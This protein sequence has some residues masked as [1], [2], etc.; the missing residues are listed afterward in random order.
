VI[1]PPTGQN[2][3]ANSRFLG[4]GVAIYSSGNSNLELEVT[5]CLIDGC[6]IRD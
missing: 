1:E 2:T 6:G 4:G 3:I 5:G